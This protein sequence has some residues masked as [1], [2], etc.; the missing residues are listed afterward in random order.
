MLLLYK[1]VSTRLDFSFSCMRAYL[2]TTLSL[3]D[4]MKKLVRSLLLIPLM[5][6]G[7][8][9]GFLGAASP[10]QADPARVECALIRTAQYDQLVEIMGPD[11]QHLN[12]LVRLAF[13]L[14]HE[15]GYS[16]QRAFAQVF[17]PWGSQAISLAHS[18]FSRYCTYTP[19]S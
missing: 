2:E 18:H 5:A 12:A 19:A 10:A 11:T 8:I 4:I 14:E 13:Q 15:R 7:M 16:S 17:S 6:A 9:A 3:G 1:V